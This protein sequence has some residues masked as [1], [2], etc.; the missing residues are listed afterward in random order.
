[1]FDRAH[2]LS[3]SWSRFSDK[4]DLLKTV[5]S[6]LKYPRHLVNFVIK[7]FVD[8]KACDQRQLLSPSKE[9]DDTVREILPLRD[10]IAY[11]Q[12]LQERARDDASEPAKAFRSAQ[13]M[14]KQI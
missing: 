6:R 5:F 4:C 14:Q 11:C 7:S 8:S 12:T 2:R 13:E 3:S 9:K 1:M 10:Q